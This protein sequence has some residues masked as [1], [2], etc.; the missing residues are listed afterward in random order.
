MQQ[1]QNINSHKEV[2]FEWRHPLITSQV[3]ITLPEL[4][5]KSLKMWSDWGEMREYSIDAQGPISISYRFKTG[6]KMQDVQY[7]IEQNILK[8]NSP[9]A[10]AERTESPFYY[11]ITDARKHVIFRVAINQN[12]Q[13]IGIKIFDEKKEN[14][15]FENSL[16]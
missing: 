11:E 1:T 10:K 4:D 7:L 8:V 5:H 16:R 6:E 13:P 2:S 9:V 3:T 12:G 15:L 14:L